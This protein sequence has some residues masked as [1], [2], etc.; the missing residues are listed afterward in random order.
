MPFEYL[1]ENLNSSSKFEYLDE[2]SKKQPSISDVIN[3]IKEKSG[4]NTSPVGMLEKGYEYAQKG[5]NKLAEYSAEGMGQLGYDPRVAGAI[6][7]VVAMAPDILTSITPLPPA[8]EANQTAISLGKRAIGFTKRFQ[9][10]PLAREQ[11]A[12]AVETALENDILSTNFQKMFDKSVNL[13]K[14]TGQELGDLR[15]SIGPQK[16]DEVFSSLENLRGTLT[17]G[18]TG[19]VWDAINKRI[20]NAQETLLGLIDNKSEVTLDELVDAKNR[21]KGAV[22]YLSDNVTQ[23]DTKRIVSNI[24]KSI[25][26]IFSNSGGDIKKLKELKRTYGSAEKLQEGLNNLISSDQGNNVIPLTSYLAAGSQM[27]AGNPLMAAG[28]LGFW[29]T[30][31]NIAKVSSAKAAYNMPKTLTR[32]IGLVGPSIGLV[33]RNKRK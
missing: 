11:A 26:N 12:K 18:R 14:K 28:S 25:E 19:G 31:G 17:K 33:K 27:A 16:I 30:L 10:T 5:A 8:G 13:A 20:D 7:T 3:L 4:Y 1:D 6:N 9:K 23:A 24:E 2:L 32:S 29:R 21:I 22:S 15:K